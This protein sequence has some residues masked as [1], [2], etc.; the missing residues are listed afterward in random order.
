M[1]ARNKIIKESLLSIR[2]QSFNRFTVKITLNRYNNQ[3][4]P[5]NSSIPMTDF[6]FIVSYEWNK[7]WI[8]WQ[9]IVKIKQS[10]KV[11]I[12]ENKLQSVGLKSMMIS[13]FINEDKWYNISM[14]SVDYQEAQTLNKHL[15]KYEREKF[16]IFTT[17]TYSQCYDFNICYI[18]F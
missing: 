7:I 6:I 5:F 9:L 18:L 14:I 3:R 16:N 12:Q 8:S 10:W 13:H 17:L 2:Q 15:K 4:L 1:E 11:N